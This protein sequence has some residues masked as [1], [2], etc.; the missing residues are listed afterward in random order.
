MIVYR[1]D[2][3]AA[4]D[5]LTMAVAVSQHQAAGPGRTAP[6]RFS[7]THLRRHPAPTP[8]VRPT[9]ANRPQPCPA[10]M[11]DRDTVDA[12]FGE[13]VPWTATIVRGAIDDRIQPRHR[14]F[15]P[16]RATKICDRA[17]R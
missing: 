11:C 9:T 4:F 5:L 3:D 15:H 10:V 14:A 13:F 6:G 16:A 2:A 1:I 7:G 8:G 12:N 17:G